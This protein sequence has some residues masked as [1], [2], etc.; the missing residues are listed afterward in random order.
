MSSR[1]VCI[2]ICF[3]NI[4]IH[5]LTS[6]VW[7]V[8]GPWSRMILRQWLAMKTHSLPACW[9][10]VAPIDWIAQMIV[11]PNTTSINCTVCLRNHFLPPNRCNHRVLNTYWSKCSI[12]DCVPLTSIVV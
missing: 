6:R 12:L 7:H 8:V 9:Q 1:L 4:T 11:L 10:I 2:W 3:S 5:S